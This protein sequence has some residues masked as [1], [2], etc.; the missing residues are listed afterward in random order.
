[1]IFNSI[2]HFLVILLAFCT[3][4]TFGD[5]ST[6]TPSPVI[7]TTLSNWQKIKEGV[8]G[9]FSDFYV[10]Q[11]VRRY[12][13]LEDFFC[14]TKQELVQKVSDAENY[15]SNIA[16]RQQ[17]ILDDVKDDAKESIRSALGKVDQWKQ[18]VDSF[19]KRVY[20]ST[21][22]QVDKLTNEWKQSITEKWNGGLDNIIGV[23][24]AIEI[25]DKPAALT[26]S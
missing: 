11:I 6:T 25:K 21:A 16:R 4:K 24:K 13:K 17:E 12:Q 23:I 8:K 20:N 14:K 18:D 26:R 1:M 19:K 15:L 3:F 7:P 9:L 22:D 10:S 5:E 2:F